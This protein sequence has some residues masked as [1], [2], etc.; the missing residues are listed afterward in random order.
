MLGDVV[1][2]DGD[3]APLLLGLSTFTLFFMMLSHT[4]GR[5]YLPRSL[6]RLLFSALM[7]MASFTPLSNHLGSVVRISVLS[8]S[9]VCSSWS[10]CICF[11]T[12]EV[13]EL[14]LRCSLNLA[15]SDLSVSP[16]YVASHSSHLILYTGPTTFFLSTGSLG[17]TNS[18]RN[19]FVGLKY[20]GMPYFPN[21]RL[22][23]SEN[24]LMY[25]MTT[26]IF[27]FLSLSDVSFTGSGLFTSLSSLLSSFN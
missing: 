5:L 20:V 12:S 6:L 1:R 17:F 13:V 21:T 23:C 4:G 24:P 10:V 18:W 2:D 19:V 7:W 22:I 16:T 14:G 15:F 27:L 26:G 25:G 9:T 11:A 3:E 8:S